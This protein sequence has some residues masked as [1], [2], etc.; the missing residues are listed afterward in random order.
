MTYRF[1]WS[2]YARDSCA[3]FANPAQWGQP[4]CAAVLALKQQVFGEQPGEMPVCKRCIDSLVVFS[5]FRQDFWAN[6]VTKVELSQEIGVFRDAHLLTGWVV[7]H[8]TADGR[9]WVAT[10]NTLAAARVRATAYT[11]SIPEIRV[12]TQS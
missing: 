10:E 4:V 1:T 3:H 12:L 2:S 11:W 6:A 5:K 8:H 7:R 9:T